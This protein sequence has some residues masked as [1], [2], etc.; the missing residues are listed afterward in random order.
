MFNLFRL[1]A[2]I[3]INAVTFVAGME[4]TF[5]SLNLIVRPDG[6][7]GLTANVNGPVPPAEVTGVNEVAAVP[8]VSVLVAIDCT[9]V[10]GPLTSRANGWL[11]VAPAGDGKKARQRNAVPGIGV[12]IH[13]I[14]G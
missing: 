6:R 5:G 3:N 10:S 7:A 12:P 8:A 4:I 9:A 2:P 1:M 14:F 13:G 11:A